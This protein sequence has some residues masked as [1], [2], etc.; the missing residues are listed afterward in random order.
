[1]GVRS[2][3]QLVGWVQWQPP[4]SKCG[5]RWLRADFP[6]LAAFGFSSSPHVPIFLPFTPQPI[7][8]SSSPTLKVFTNA[9]L[10]TGLRLHRYILLLCLCARQEPPPVVPLYL[11]NLSN[12][13]IACR[14]SMYRFH[15]SKSLSPQK[16]QIFPTSR[17]PCRNHPRLAYG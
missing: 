11:S 16:L 12:R 5:N 10:Q 7:S 17:K 13:H 9:C 1:M 8:S 6:R 2:A 3:K 15:P 14:L 4:T